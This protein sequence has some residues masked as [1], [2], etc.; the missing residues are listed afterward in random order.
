MTTKFNILPRFGIIGLTIGSLCFAG[1]AMAQAESKKNSDAAMNSE[2]ATT[3]EKPSSPQSSSLEQKDKTFPK[4]AFKGGMMEVAMGKL[5]GEQG[6]SADVK[7]F[8]KRMVTDHSKAND[9]LKSI[10]EKKGVKL[11]SKELSE[12]WKSDKD[13]MDA[14][15]KDHEKDLAEFQKEAKEGTD[16]D[17]KEFAEKT[18]KVVQ[19]HLDLAKET[20]SKLQ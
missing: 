6:Q 7:K 12:K 20:Q 17:L 15:V 4:K 3:K 16:P 2:V 9:E 10:A 19:E 11:P 1:G 14:M 13:Y 8:G 5:A 18:A